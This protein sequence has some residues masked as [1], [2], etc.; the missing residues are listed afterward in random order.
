MK[1]AKTFKDI[2]LIKMVWLLVFV[3]G[4]SQSSGSA[5]GTETASPAVTK[6]SA[7]STKSATALEITDTPDISPTLEPDVDL[8]NLAGEQ[9]IFWHTWGGKLGEVINEI[10][11]DWNENNEWGL[12]VESLYQGNADSINK[13]IFMQQNIEDLPNLALGYIHQADAWDNLWPVEDLNS[14]IDDP[15]IGLSKEEQVDFYDPLWWKSQIGDKRLGLPVQQYGN[16]LF[17]NQSWANELGFDSPPST[18]EEFKDQAC[19]AFNAVLLDD[20]DENNGMGGWVVSTDYTAT[21]GWLYA[22]GA[23][24]YYPDDSGEMKQIYE[25]KTPETEKTFRYLRSLFDDGCAWLSAGENPEV[26]FASRRALFR[27]GDI[28]DIPIQEEAFRSKSNQDKWVVISYPS[29]SGSGAF[30]V[31]GPALILL[32]SSQEKQLA[33]WLFLK[34][35]SEPE[36]QARMIEAAGTLPIREST[37]D[38]LNE[39]REQNPHWSQAVALMDDAKSEPGIQSWQTV[40]WA[41]GDATRQLFLSYFTIDDISGL[42]EFLDKTAHELYLGPEKSGLLDTPTFTPS[43][44]LT[45]TVTPTSSVTPTASVTSSPTNTPT[46]EN[47]RQATETPQAN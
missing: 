33:S 45:P 21:L 17:Y 39:Y 23:E 20:N 43:A 35:F 26:E 14:Y 7:T 29:P 31:Y 27:S 8:R 32:S 46:P 22:H 30:D 9:I 4:C 44:T 18:P 16:Y 19:A 5:V 3:V 10:V 1:K 24:Y 6:I 36:Q 40:R 2:G 37:L 25:F 13:K 11:G 12:T 47:T 15:Y 42:L 28:S 38:L 41:L 34:W